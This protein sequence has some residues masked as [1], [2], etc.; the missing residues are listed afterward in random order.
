MAR[1]MWSAL[2][3]Q[4]KEILAGVKMWC[5]IHGEQIGAYVMLL[6]TLGFFLVIIGSL[7]GQA[8]TSGLGKGLTSLWEEIKKMILKIILALFSIVRAIIRLL[9]RFFGLFIRK[10]SS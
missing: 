8:F 4:I 5:T 9:S 3:D 10:K 6:L 7:F 2:S 1:S